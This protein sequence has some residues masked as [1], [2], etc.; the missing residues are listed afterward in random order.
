MN[1]I[2]RQ[3]HIRLT[4]LR[5]FLR[6]YDASNTTA[7]SS[8]AKAACAGLEPGSLIFIVEPVT[9]PFGL[10]SFSH[11]EE[12]NYRVSDFAIVVRIEDSKAMVI[13]LT[14]NTYELRF[15]ESLLEERARKSIIDRKKFS[16]VAVK[17]VLP[18]ALTKFQELER[19]SALYAKGGA[20]RNFMS[21]NHAEEP[22]AA[23]LAACGVHLHFAN[24]N[25]QPADIGSI[26][27]SL[28]NTD[29]KLPD[30]NRA[31]LKETF[32]PLSND[33]AELKTI[34]VSSGGFGSQG[35]Q[36]DLLSE[37][38]SDLNS[39]T[40]QEITGFNLLQSWGGD[41]HGAKKNM[42]SEELVSEAVVEAN[43]DLDRNHL[44]RKDE[45][46]INLED[47]NLDKNQG[48]WF[49]GEEN[50]N[51]TE[52]SFTNNVQA[53]EV[54]DVG[55]TDDV[56]KH[57][58]EAITDLLGAPQ[59]TTST[60]KL[61][62]EM[63][64]IHI[65]DIKPEERESIVEKENNLEEES[66]FTEQAPFA[67]SISEVDSS[68][69]PLELPESELTAYA[70]GEQPILE[71]TISISAL[72]LEPMGLEADIQTGDSSV[73]FSSTDMMP[74]K[75]D[76]FQEPKVVMNEMASLMSKLELQVARAA[77][78]LA[79]KVSEVEKRLAT[80]IDALLTLVNQ[81]DKDSYA[82]LVVRIDVLSKEFEALF[83]T[84]K[85]ELAEK[86][87]NSREQV[88]AKLS[89]YKEK[90]DK[91]ESEERQILTEEFKQ[92]KVQFDQL[93]KDQE[94][95]LNKLVSIQTE[96]LN[97]RMR[98]LD[99]VLE[100]S[101]VNFGVQLEEHFSSFRERLEEK[102][103]RLLKTFDHQL[104]A[105]NHD[106]ERSHFAGSEQL[107][108]TKNQ[109][110]SKLERLMEITEIDLSR[111]VRKAHTESL[112]PRLKE[113]KQIIEAMMQEMMQTF[114]EHSF[115][116]AKAQSEAAEHSLVLA[117]QQL[118]ELVEERLAK[119][120]VVGRNQQTGLE[121]I[122]RS[123]ADRLEHNTA[124]VVQLLK[125]A[126]Q[127]INECEAVCAKLA[128]S[129]NLD[130]DPKLTALCQDVYSKV[131]SLK[132]QLRNNL[133]AI[134]DE[135]CL[136]LED[137]TKNHHVRLNTRR[138]ELVQ[139]VRSASDEGLL[140]IRQAIHDAFYT[141]QSQRE[142]YME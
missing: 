136:S 91:I 84:L 4:D 10:I 65:P 115:S 8:W 28:F 123:A 64:N 135:D 137:S 2:L 69:G 80:N 130:G 40:P 119:L 36:I 85:T 29:M 47:T 104:E 75:L 68:V 35:K 62:P 63:A 25:K 87:A 140:S 17:P 83:D 51:N 138:A 139:Q 116:Q 16:F 109:F 110:F 100:N 5:D 32:V 18:L 54:P 79:V 59:F 9:L 66:I 27:H 34:P 99:G 142:K 50:I 76:D 73:I 82:E 122:F 89:L 102:I 70:A 93:V 74:S 114:A 131:E 86:A 96:V 12:E 52:S 56:Y 57:L 11:K 38:L 128:Q 30:S 78:K 92:N 15:L 124:A 24:M 112:L 111:Q 45:L 97:E 37:K 3:T 46:P 126:E 7:V 13:S 88:K 134:L 6:T 49:S 21:V 132:V 127:E 106:I 33:F 101:S 26:C 48:G 71:E 113:R 1:S 53:Q 125:Q 72:D 98:A 118:K 133:E 41:K 121:E 117:R 14:N 107:I 103:L 55:Q 19:L 105:L 31:Q 61:S 77:K 20:R 94:N 43:N 58:S 44:D 108:S 90:I 129:Y 39:P 141:I 120:D 42:L 67:A 81:E 60:E 23:L 95:E 22:A